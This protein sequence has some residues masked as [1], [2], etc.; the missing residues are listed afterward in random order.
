MA[1]TKRI[2]RSSQDKWQADIKALEAK[3]KK[4][5]ERYLDLKKE[6]EELQKNPPSART[7]R[8]TTESL[9]KYFSS[10]PKTLTKLLQEAG[11]DQD[12]LNKLLNEAFKESNK[13]KSD[14]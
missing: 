14:E 13:N 10:D 2:R 6:Y 5:E 8:R 11:D 12:K 4:A 1:E 7:R 9:I 3:V